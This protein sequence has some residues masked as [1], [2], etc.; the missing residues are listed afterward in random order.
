M[1]NACALLSNVS[2]AGTRDPTDVETKCL[3]FGRR[4]RR[5]QPT[6]LK[7][8]LIHLRL[9]VAL[10]APFEVDELPLEIIVRSHAE[11]T[12]KHRKLLLERIPID[13]RKFS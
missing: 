11:L 7:S 12:V 3:K 8:A 1:A 10:G 2:T 9:A 6:P 4:R 5:A 13:L